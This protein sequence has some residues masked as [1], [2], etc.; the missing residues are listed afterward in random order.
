MR[1]LQQE[2]LHHAFKGL[3]VMQHNV[4]RFRCGLA[5]KGFCRARL[6]P[7]GRARFFMLAGMRG[8][9][10]IH[11]CLGGSADFAAVPG[12]GAVF[13]ALEH[14]A[15]FL[16]LGSGR[17]FRGFRLLNRFRR[18]LFFCGAGG[19]RGTT[20]WRGGFFLGRIVA[21]SRLWRSVHGVAKV[22]GKIVK[23]VFFFFFTAQE[24]KAHGCR[25]GTKQAEK[26]L[27]AFLQHLHFAVGN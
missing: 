6:F 3:R 24:C 9:E 4:F 1:Q 23:V 26:S 15:V 8:P 5:G 25:F 27:R 2:L 13:K 10:N 17:W 18:R 19:W 21:R 16:T 20:L 14:V 7:A 11:G 12:R 22:D